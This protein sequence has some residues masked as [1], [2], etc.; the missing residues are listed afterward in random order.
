MRTAAPIL[1]DSWAPQYRGICSA[2]SV[3]RPVLGRDFGPDDD[4]P[5]AEPSSCSVTTCGGV[6]TTGI[7]EVVGR[8]I[9]INGR[10]HTVIGVMPPQVHVSRE[11]AAVGAAG[12]LLREDGSGDERNHQMFARM[13]PG[14]TLDQASTDLDGDRRVDSPPP[15][16]S[17]TRTGAPSCVRC[18]EWMLPAR[19]S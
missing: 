11:P 8:S 5:G 17:R 7:A 10:A 19:S 13:K 3:L 15:T 18:S 12:A 16:R 9:S 2:C 1:S 4:R 14:V 6:G